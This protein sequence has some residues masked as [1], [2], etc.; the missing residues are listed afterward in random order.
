MS[1]FATALNNFQL[2]QRK[3]K[4]MEHGAVSKVRTHLPVRLDN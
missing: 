3:Q 4:E 1:D 2:A